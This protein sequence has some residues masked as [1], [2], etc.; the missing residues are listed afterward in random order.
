[1]NKK[2]N[3]MLILIVNN[4]FFSIIFIFAKKIQNECRGLHLTLL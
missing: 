3:K 1:M 2:Y 4:Y